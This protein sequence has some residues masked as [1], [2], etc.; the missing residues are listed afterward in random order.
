ME[1]KITYHDWTRVMG[2]VSAFAGWVARLTQSLQQYLF[3]KGV[4][5]EGG[6]RPFPAEIVDPLGHCKLS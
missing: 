4:L 2:D 6:S 1:P 3:S 5:K